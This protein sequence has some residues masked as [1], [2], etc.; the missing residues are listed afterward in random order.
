MQLCKKALE[1][2]PQEDLFSMYDT[3]VDELAISMD[4]P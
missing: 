3:S 4:Q 2:E 1:R